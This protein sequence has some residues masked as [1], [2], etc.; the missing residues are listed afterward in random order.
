MSINTTV[1]VGFDGT[2][3]KTGLK[4]IGGMFGKF[5][6]E[7]GIGAARK[8]GELGTDLLGKTLSF[9]AEAPGLFLDY[10]G[11][12]KDLS[13]L[14]GE[15]IENLQLLQETFR[16]AG[17]DSIDTGKSILLLSKSIA[18]AKEE[19]LSNEN[20]PMVKIFDQLK[21]GIGDLMRMKPAAQIETIFAAM[22]ANVPEFGDQVKIMQALFGKGGI[23]MLQV[24][25]DHFAG[26]MEKA[27]SNLAGIAKM[28]KEEV[29]GLE[30]LGDEL[31]RLP[32]M[33]MRIF[34]NLL[35]GIFGENT[36]TTAAENLGKVFDAI[37]DGGEEIQKLGEKMR[38]LFD[39][40]GKNGFGQLLKDMQIGIGSF[41]SDIGS[42]IGTA[43]STAVDNYFKGTML[44]S[45]MTKSMA[46]QQPVGSSQSGYKFGFNS[47]E[48]TKYL[49]KTVDI[50][51]RIYHEGGGAVFQ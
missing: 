8:V 7:V 22:N 40:V 9:F 34:R 51:Q 5:N 27:K 21:L 41:A 43:F 46:Q 36:G 10:A 12:L 47:E 26:T 37:G 39:Y 33:K 49:Q 50:L 32:I 16:L 38:K 17:V 19:A 30:S 45:M 25:R 35:D 2:A 13:T 4:S 42:K 29:D 6:K 28:S 11:E 20:G 24:F 15:S 3:V 1:K 23:K 14:T 48:G 44:G 18:Q 31:G